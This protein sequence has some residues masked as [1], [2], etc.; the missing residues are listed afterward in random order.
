MRELGKQLGQVRQRE[1]A[2]NVRERH[3]AVPVEVIEVGTRD[4]IEGLLACP[5]PEVHELDLEGLQQS[6][7]VEGEWFPF[8]VCLSELQFV[9]DDDGTIFVAVD[10]FPDRLVQEAKAGLIELASQLYQGE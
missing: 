4:R 1:Q 6:H 2:S 8:E 3:D 7:A 5:I 10:N 9:L